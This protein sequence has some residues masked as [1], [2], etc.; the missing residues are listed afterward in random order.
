MGSAFTPSP[1]HLA[2]VLVDKLTR[3]PQP[4]RLVHGRRT[5]PWVAE[6]LQSFQ[7]M[8]VYCR[9]GRCLHLNMFAAAVSQQSPTW[10]T[11]PKSLRLPSCSPQYADTLR[12]PFCSSSR[13][14]PC[15]VPVVT[16]TQQCQYMLI[17]S[18]ILVAQNAPSP[19]FVGHS[20][21]DV[22]PQC[23]GGGQRCGGC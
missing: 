18:T 20:A 1:V 14:P 16:S 2:R 17:F 15:P 4:N 3:P 11:M 6:P 7:L 19:E 22:M 8:R 10:E 23:G 12:A 21:F 9:H 5:V 13:L